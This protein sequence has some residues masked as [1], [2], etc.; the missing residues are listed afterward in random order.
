ME[1]LI[2]KLE[3][4]W[5]KGQTFAASQQNLYNSQSTTFAKYGRS[6]LLDAH[7]DF[8]LDVKYSDFA[9]FELQLWL[10]E[11]SS[12]TSELSGLAYCAENVL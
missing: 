8:C 1:A 10:P 7:G 2:D 6:V 5:P 9:I 11:C 3:Q 4:W 12:R